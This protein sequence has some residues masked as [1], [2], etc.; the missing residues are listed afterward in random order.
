[1]DWHPDQMNANRLLH[2]RPSLLQNQIHRYI[3]IGAD[4]TKQKE[5]E[6][7]IWQQANHD[8]L[9][10]LPSRHRLH[11]LLQQILEKSRRDG[12]T[13]AVLHVDLD[14]FGQVN[15]TLGHG[16]GDQLIV[17]AD[18]RISACLGLDADRVAH[19]GRDEFVVVLGAL[20]DA[21]RRVEQVAGDILRTMSLSDSTY[22]CRHR[23]GGPQ[24]HAGGKTLE[25]RS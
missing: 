15:E 20:A 9:T 11:E 7:V 2:D 19:L 10:H 5:A 24:S 3:G 1:M 22:R 4:I 18:R 14:H 17:E 16:I 21:A 25:I 13:L 23:R 6:A 12:L 8:L